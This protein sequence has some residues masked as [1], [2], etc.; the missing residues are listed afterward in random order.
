M[1]FSSPLMGADQL[2]FEN[3]YIGDRP[4]FETIYNYKKQCGQIIRFPIFVAV[5]K[6]TPYTVVL[7]NCLILFDFCI[8]LFCLIPFYQ[9]TK[10]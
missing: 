1:A 2:N 3:F 5:D 10:P 4:F 9:P 6:L 8:F 7:N